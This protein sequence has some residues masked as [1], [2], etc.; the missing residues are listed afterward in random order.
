MIPVLLVFVG[1]GLGAVL[2]YLVGLLLPVWE[3]EGIPW[4]TFAVNALGA[5]LIGFLM[6]LSREVVCRRSIACFSS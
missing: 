1:G 2:R 3:G 6:G 5:F 4:A